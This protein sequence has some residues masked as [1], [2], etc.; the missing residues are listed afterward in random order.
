MEAWILKLNKLRVYA[1][2]IKWTQ[3]HVAQVRLAQDFGP[4]K[5]GDVLNINMNTKCASRV[6][7]EER[8]AA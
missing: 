3:G 1:V 4:F 5:A 7:T 8:R 2:L 6:N